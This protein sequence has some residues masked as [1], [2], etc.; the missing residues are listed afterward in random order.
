MGRPSHPEEGRFAS[1]GASPFAR[2][3]RHP[4]PA[5]LERVIRGQ[6]Q[7]GPGQPSAGGVPGPY[8]S[9]EVA[10][11]FGKEGAS[12]LNPQPSIRLG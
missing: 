6:G 8:P 10:P 9:P 1:C 3:E 11:L 7:G 2:F 12:W 4:L 5:E